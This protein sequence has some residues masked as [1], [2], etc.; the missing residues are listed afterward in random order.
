MECGEFSPLCAGD[1]S[2]SSG[3]GRGVFPSRWTRLCLAGS[4]PG[5]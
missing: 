4:R 5:G 1:L 3:L 2:P